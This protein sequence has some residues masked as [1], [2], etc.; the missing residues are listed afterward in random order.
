MLG[1]NQ[2]AP[3]LHR[4]EGGVEH[5]ELVESWL[6]GEIPIPEIEDRWSNG[7][8]VRVEIDGPAEL[9]AGVATTIAIRVTNNKAGHDFPTGP[10]DMI[11]SW[12]EVKVF[13]RHG[14]VLQQVGGLNAR[15]DV[16]GSPLHLKA[17]GFDREGALIDRHNLWDLVGKRNARALFAGM[18]DLAAVEL[19][20]P[21]SARSTAGRGHVDGDASI[22]VI[23]PQEGHVR[24]EARLWYRKAHPTFL[25]RVCRDE[26]LEAPRT[27]VAK[28][29]ATFVVR[30]AVSTR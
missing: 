25:G 12:L 2:Y 29:E 22:R 20:C 30:E 18:T 26:G 10:L 1:A 14:S 27:L 28:A 13:D 19:S 6:R 3:I 24:V 23:S 16:V 9:S 11:E 21:S 15:G 5:T 8:V 4:L 7:P 17:D